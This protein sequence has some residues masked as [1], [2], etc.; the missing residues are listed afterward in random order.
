[1]DTN[2]ANRR[3]TVALSPNLVRFS[4]FNS[5]T[6]DFDSKFNSDRKPQYTEDVTTGMRYGKIPERGGAKNPYSQTNPF[7]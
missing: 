5:T 6:K 2:T 3:G 7:P 4:T 1:L